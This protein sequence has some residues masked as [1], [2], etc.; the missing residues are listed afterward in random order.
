MG[1]YQILVSLIR[2]LYTPSH[3]VE[4]RGT[5][6]INLCLQGFTSSV[7]FIFLLCTLILDE[8]EESRNSASGVL[9]DLTRVL[10]EFDYFSY[11]Q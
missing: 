4:S 5:G 6:Q 9:R 8:C 2:K 11:C 1:R 3:A 7:P 10:K